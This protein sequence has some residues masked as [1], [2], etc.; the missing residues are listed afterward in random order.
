MSKMSNGGVRMKNAR[1]IYIEQL[2]SGRGLTGYMNKKRKTFTHLNST[3]D[4]D[5]AYRST[6]DY[7]R[8]LTQ[9]DSSIPT[10]LML[11]KNI[12]RTKSA[13]EMTPR[14]SVNR[15]TMGNPKYKA[16]EDYYDE[17]QSLKQEMKTLREENSNFRAKIRRL[18]EDN[19]RKMK[20]IDALYNTNKD[21]DLRR[22]LT[23]PSTDR[24][25]NSSTANVVMSLKQRVFKLES[26]LKQKETTIDEMKSDPR[27]TKSTE[28]EIQNRALFS[29]LERQKVARSN[30]IQNDYMASLNEEQKNAVRKLHREKDELKTENES[31][32]KRIDDFEKGG[33]IG[34]LSSRSVDR[35]NDKEL[36]Q[37][38]DK[39]QRECEHYEHELEQMKDDFKQMRRERDQFRDRFD[40]ANEDLEEIKRERD[41]L[42]K[43]LERTN[44]DLEN[45]QRE[46]DKYKQKPGGRSSPLSRYDDE[47]RG[48]IRPRTPITQRTQSPLERKPISQLSKGAPRRGSS[49]EEPF[50]GSEKVNTSFGRSSGQIRSRTGSPNSSFTE[51]KA[52]IPLK[53][54]TKNIRNKN[55]TPE[56]DRRVKS[57]REKHAATVIQREWRRHDKSRKKPLQDPAKMRQVNLDKWSSKLGSS[58][59]PSEILSSTASPTFG[60]PGSGTMKNRPSSPNNLNENALKTVQASLRG[61]LNRNEIDKNQDRSFDSRAR[62]KSPSRSDRFRAADS[63]GEDFVSTPSRTTKAKSSPERNRHESPDRPRGDSLT[64]IRQPPSSHDQR[65]S[66]PLAGKSGGS[67]QDLLDDRIKL[68]S[69]S[70]ISV[71]D[72]EMS[73]KPGRFVPPSVLDERSQSPAVGKISSSRHDSFDGR[74][75]LGSGNPIS[76]N[77]RES[78]SKMH[79]PMSPSGND[80]RSQSPPGFRSS[81]SSRPMSSDRPNLATGHRIGAKDREPPSMRRTP[82]PPFDNPRSTSPT[83]GKI[84]GSKQSLPND[85]SKVDSGSRIRSSERDSASKIP[86]SFSPSND[87][88]PSRPMISDDSHMPTRKNPNNSKQSMKNI[89]EHDDDDDV[90]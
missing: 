10:E 44:D 85:R 77:D 62:S 23:G 66:S 17:I 47:I 41:Q 49:D 65:P 8:H 34:Q 25:N 72:R 75:K 46:H 30:L 48:D 28:F 20:E 39:L 70:R 45:M 60:R 78:P 26:Q 37:K 82:S 27:W 3:D 18:E 13:S 64:R 90:F 86:R 29:E 14:N 35:G 42:R 80:H 88:R 58:A 5:F 12:P 51:K 19:V 59:K 61:Y 67:K 2:P 56:D 76:F 43:K 68:G 52:V 22:T 55:W 9:Q 6:P 57:F 63:D 31:L 38:F 71:K 15:S 73:S 32:K 11:A 40:Q 33:H 74:N 24:N 1:E 16:Q 84:S 89:P 87:D 54:S 50:S 81:I 21:G 83:V 7:L 36:N 79:R 53:L 4:I 69:N